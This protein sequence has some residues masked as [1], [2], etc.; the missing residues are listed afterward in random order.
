MEEKNDLSDKNIDQPLE[1]NKIASQN[2]YLEDNKEISN[3]ENIII[4]N[5]ND[6][7]EY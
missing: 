1:N 5:K 7:N 4:P 3:S 2:N 6:I